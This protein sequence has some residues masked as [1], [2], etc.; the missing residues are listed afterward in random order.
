MSD[1]MYDFSTL[2]EIGMAYPI[3]SHTLLEPLMAEPWPQSNTLVEVGEN[4]KWKKN[5]TSKTHRELQ[6]ARDADKEEEEEE[7]E[8][9][10][11]DEDE[12]DEEGE[13]EEGE[14][15][16]GDDEEEEEEA[17]E[18]EDEDAGYPEDNVPS[19]PL[20]D[21]FFMHNE[22]LRKRYNEVELDSFMKLLNIK[23]TV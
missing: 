16:E 21:R 10:E 5:T 11:E 8:E 2:N 12:D 4:E 1:Y 20:D 19:V 18:A 3:H 13:G 23:P 17:E 22:K 14:E 9:D 15:G 6:E 7:E